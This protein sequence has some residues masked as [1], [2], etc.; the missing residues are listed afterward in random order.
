VTYSRADEVH[1]FDRADALS[2]QKCII[3]NMPGHASWQQCTAE[4]EAKQS[5]DA[6]DALALGVDPLVVSV[7]FFPSG[8][9][10]NPIRPRV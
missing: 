9:S 7:V 3:R 2:D 8:L 10:E 1:I 6:A 5:R 4:A